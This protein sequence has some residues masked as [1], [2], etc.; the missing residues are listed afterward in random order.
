MD[1]SSILLPF[2]IFG[3]IFSQKIFMPIWNILQTFG[4]FMVILVRFSRLGM[5]HQEKSGNPGKEAKIERL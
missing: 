2:G 5:L 4:T 3:K 1:I